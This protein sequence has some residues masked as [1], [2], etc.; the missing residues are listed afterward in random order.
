MTDA[1]RHPARENLV[2]AGLPQLEWERLQPHLVPV[3]LEQGAVLHDTRDCTHVHFPTTAC[4]SLLYLTEDGYTPE[5]AVVGNEGMLGNTEFFGNYAPACQNLVLVTGQAYKLDT[6]ILKR[7]LEHSIV[8]NRLIMN[9]NQTLFQ[10]MA[11]TIVSSRR[12]PLEEQLCRRL[13]LGLDRI[14]CNTIAMTHEM[15]ANMLNV[16]REGISI[17]AS[18]L[19]DEGLIEYHRGQITVIDRAGLEARAGECYASQY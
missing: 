11:Q 3:K 2:L 14:A 16:R 1:I 15:L 9:Y 17:A 5:I 8:L 6:K 18:H 12:Q 13:L 7:E 10:Q 4:V 19:R